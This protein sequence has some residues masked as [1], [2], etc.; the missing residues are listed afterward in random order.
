MIYFVEKGFGHLLLKVQNQFEDVQINIHAKNIAVINYGT[1]AWTSD[2]TF[3]GIPHCNNTICANG[4]SDRM[5]SRC[6]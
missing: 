6:V 5:C 4:Y 1:E 3:I 2:C